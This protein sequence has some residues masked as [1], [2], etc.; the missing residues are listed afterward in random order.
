MS[1]DKR[2]SPKSPN[3]INMKGQTQEAKSASYKK[4]VI[5]PTDEVQSELSR[6]LLQSEIYSK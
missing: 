2:K 6:D 5:D 4:Q 1:I 3:N